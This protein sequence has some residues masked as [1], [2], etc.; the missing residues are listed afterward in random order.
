M[1]SSKL[2]T[3]SLSPSLSCPS[4]P[5]LSSPLLSSP[6]PYL[7]LFLLSLT[8]SLFS[9]RTVAAVSLLLCCLFTFF[10]VPVRLLDDL[11]KLIAGYLI[12]DFRCPKTHLV[13]TKVCSP[14]SE[15]CLPLQMDLSLSA[16]HSQLTVLREVAKL[17]DFDWLLTEVNLALQSS[18]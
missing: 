2:S 15:L 13:S 1:T 11:E 8:S 12:Q 10:S 7:L 16:I 3:G 6:L 9:N 14:V 4:S 17:H 18:S 5:L